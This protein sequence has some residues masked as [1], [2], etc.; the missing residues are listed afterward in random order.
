MDETLK[1]DSR[2]QTIDISIRKWIIAY[3]IESVLPTDKQYE[4]DEPKNI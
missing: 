4:Y 1:L 3:K 2:R